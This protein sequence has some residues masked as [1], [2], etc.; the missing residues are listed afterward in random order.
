MADGGWR[1]ADGG[2]EISGGRCDL[3]GQPDPHVRLICADRPRRTGSRQW[4]NSCNYGQVSRD[5]NARTGMFGKLTLRYAGRV[6]H[7]GIGIGRAY[8][9]QHVLMLIHD[10]DVT[11]SDTTTGEIIQELTIH[12]ER[13]RQSRQRKTPRSED[14]GVN[15]DSTH[16]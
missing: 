6:R 8:A 14:R 3:V 16:P 4:C 7:I 2:C 1:M 9:G 10:T 15:D 13:D 11:V 12:P 5:R